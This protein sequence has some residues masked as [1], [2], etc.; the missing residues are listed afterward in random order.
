MTNSYR[1]V[2]R[3]LLSISGLLTSICVCFSVTGC[4]G[5]TG[6]ISGKI[7]HK[8]KPVVFGTI[9]FI[10]EQGKSTTG[11]ISPDG[12][13]TVSGVGI[14]VAKILV[15]SSLPASAASTGKGKSANPREKGRGARKGDEAPPP[16]S[17]GGREDTPVEVAPEVA[18]KWFPIPDSYADPAVSTLSY[19]V[20]SGVNTYDVVLN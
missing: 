19:T 11:E 6:S 12:S 14:G 2:R 15:G 16:R 1:K 7:T 18:K 20:T 4:G 10:D 13:Y 5:G 17:S 9:T 8:G 3:P